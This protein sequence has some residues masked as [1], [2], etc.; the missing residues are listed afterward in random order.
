MLD[1]E[2]GGRDDFYCYIVCNVLSVCYSVTVLEAAV[3]RLPICAKLLS[4]CPR[5]S[6]LHSAP[7]CVYVGL[8]LVSTME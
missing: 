5:V 6:R 2:E 7:Q 1:G 4:C 8:G 3:F